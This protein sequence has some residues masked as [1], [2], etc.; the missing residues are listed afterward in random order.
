MECVRVYIDYLLT[1]TKDTYEDHLDKLRKVLER[2]SKANLKMNIRKSF[3]AMLEIEYLGY[4]LNQDGIKPVPSKV[5]AILASKPPNNVKELRKFLGMLQYYCDI[6]ARRSHVLAPLSDLVGKFGHTKETR[7]K[8]TKKEPWHWHEIHQK[9]FDETLR[10]IARGVMLAYP[11][12]SEP[13]EIYTD[14]SSRQLGAV[15]VQINRP[16]AFLV[17]N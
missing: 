17:V 5:S 3:F 1:I 6:W 15:I 14:A 13:F 2:L 8:K 7:K 10:T 4:I 16:I 12:Y 11:N 9:A